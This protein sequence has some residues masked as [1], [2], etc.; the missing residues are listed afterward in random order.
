METKIS[1][2]IHMNTS[3]LKKLSNAELIKIIL[4]QREDSK[5]RHTTKPVNVKKAKKTKKVAYNHENL[6]DDD[7]FSF[8]WD[9]DYVHNENK[10][11]NKQLSKIE[12]KYNKL[13]S[14]QN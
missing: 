1:N 11:I 12:Q 8:D 10:N 14:G 2:L 7:P 3:E 13:K 5:P 9:M 6:F 4:K